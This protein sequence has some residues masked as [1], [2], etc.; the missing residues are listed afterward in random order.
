[1]TQNSSTTEKSPRN[2]KEFN[3]LQFVLHFDSIFLEKE[4]G[5][6]FH[7]FLKT[8][9]NE[10]P[11]IFLCELKELKSFKEEKLFIEESTRI[12]N[13]FI[14]QNSLREINISGK[15]KL[16]LTEHFQKLIENP[17]SFKE[18]ETFELIFYP[19]EKIVRQ[20]LYHDSWKRFLR[21][22]GG[23][24]IIKKFQS[25]SSICSPQITEYFSYKD[26]Y[27]LHPYVFERDFD[28]ANLLF[29]DTF[30]WELQST[31]LESKMNYYYSK[32]NYLPQLT[33]TKNLRAIKFECVVPFS[34]HKV[35]MTYSMFQNFKESDPNVTHVE[36]L[37]YYDFEAMKKL[38][39]EKNFENEIGSFERS[40]G[41][42]VTHLS[43]PFPFDPRITHHGRSMKYDPETETVITVNKP[44]LSGDLSYL[45]P[46]VVDFYP[47]KDSEMKK[48]KVYPIF[49]FIF[50]KYQKI[51]ENKVLFTQVFVSDFGGWMNHDSMFKMIGKKRASK[52][53]D[54][55]IKMI[56]KFPKDSKIEDF[57]EELCQEK[58]GKVVDTYG[59]ALYELKIEEKNQEFRNK[60]KI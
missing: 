7:T 43:F 45:K 15:S 8:E 38:F 36:S 37:D 52:L 4:I 24:S 25:D 51:D 18:K 1:M 22:P 44:F 29:E 14:S 16:T 59:K 13:E 6:E 19:V 48:T 56:E 26:D 23:I 54:N 2:T 17:E 47:K 46:S 10:E 50:M 3:H 20:E 33:I 9:L 21:T 40:L 30:H 53:K 39:Q 27:F 41:I 12:I 5:K 60:N 42:H 35:L 32:L 34:F 55:L 31:F 11:W 49:N 58:N 28:F 57:K